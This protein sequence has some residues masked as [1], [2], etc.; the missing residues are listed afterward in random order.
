MRK[1]LQ[2][3]FGA[4]SRASSYMAFSRKHL[5]HLVVGLADEQLFNR[6]LAG[7]TLRQSQHRGRSV[8]DLHAVAKDWQDPKQTNSTVQMPARELSG[9]QNL[10][11]G[12]H[13]MPK[14]FPTRLA[15]ATAQASRP[16]ERPSTSTRP[17]AQTQHDD[18]AAN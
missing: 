9:V 2:N 8:D 1:Q 3:R 15:Q 6:S 13:P 16:S 17:R 7:A 14:R 11:L 5:E 10:Q 12:P 18:R 4:S